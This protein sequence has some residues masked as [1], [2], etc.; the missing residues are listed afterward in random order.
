MGELHVRL[1]LSLD[2]PSSTEVGYGAHEL[3]GDFECVKH[4]FWL[5]SLDVVVG[6]STPI[7]SPSPACDGDNRMLLFVVSPG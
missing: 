7:R 4:R 1:D 2:E 5:E 3:G 6:G